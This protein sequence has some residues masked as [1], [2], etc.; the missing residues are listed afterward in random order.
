MTL[1]LRRLTRF[2]AAPPALV[3]GTVALGAVTVLLG[4]GLMATAGYL[5]SRAAEQPPILSLTVAIVGVRAFGLTRPIARYCE[6][7]AAHDLAFRALGRA[8][9]RTYE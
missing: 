8:R 7:L 9:V 4:V 3:A 2:A 6:R 5:I 1:T